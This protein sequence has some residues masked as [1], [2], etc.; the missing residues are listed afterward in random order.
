MI[1]QGIIGVKG[2]SLLSFVR[3]QFISCPAYRDGTYAGKD[4]SKLRVEKIFIK[5]VGVPLYFWQRGVYNIT[6]PELI[7]QTAEREVNE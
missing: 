3:I 6:V 5:I 2:N 7:H 1:T 4:T